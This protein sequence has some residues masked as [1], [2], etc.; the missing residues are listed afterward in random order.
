MILPLIKGLGVTLKRFFSRPVT[1]Q[2]PEE[3]RP[4]SA[5]WRGTHYFEP[6]ED[7]DTKCLACGLC[8]AVCPPRAIRLVAIERDDG[9]RYPQ[10]YEIDAV[11]CIYCGFCE[12]ACPV[13]AV[14]LSRI[15]D[16]VGRSRKG[17]VWDKEVLLK[18]GASL[19][20]VKG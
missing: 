11:R 4:V 15:Y 19:K 10:V 13:D 2:Y 1:V 16:V 17:L 20:E 12:E 3:R 18:R 7:G 14:K 5:R 8:V 6:K 9:Q